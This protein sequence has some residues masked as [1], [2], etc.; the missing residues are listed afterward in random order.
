LNQTGTDPLPAK[1]VDV[2]L[3]FSVY[4]HIRDKDAFLR[5]LARNRPRAIIGEMAVQERY[6]KQ[7][8]N[9]PKE[10][11]YIVRTLGYKTLQIV[12]MTKDYERPIVLISDL[13]PYPQPLMDAMM[14]YG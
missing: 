14:G 13:P 12:G 1:P 9:L 5:D 10:L 6:Y 4:H 8:G 2:M 3:L 7:R 11:E